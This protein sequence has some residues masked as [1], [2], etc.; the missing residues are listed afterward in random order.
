[1]KLIFHS[2]INESLMETEIIEPYFKA[3]EQFKKSYPYN[4]K[5][6]PTLNITRF[7]R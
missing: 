7:R 4:C 5:Y 6:I 3:R 1:M 2:Y